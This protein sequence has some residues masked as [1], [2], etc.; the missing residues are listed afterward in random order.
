MA[1]MPN[2]AK[3]VKLQGGSARIGQVQF[4]TGALNV[5]GLDAHSAGVLDRYARP[6]RA[7]VM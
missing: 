2:V 3:L 4:S 6:F 1:I 7:G 5:G